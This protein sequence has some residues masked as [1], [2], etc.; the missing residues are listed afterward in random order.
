MPV[1]D[2]GFKGEAIGRRMPR[3]YNFPTLS[4]RGLSRDPAPV[5]GVSDDQTRYGG[6]ENDT[7]QDRPQAKATGVY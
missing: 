2:D 1:A 3:A 7:V 6:E 4:D 5:H